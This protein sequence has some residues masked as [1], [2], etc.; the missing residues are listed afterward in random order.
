M[1]WALVESKKMRLFEYQGKILFKEM[2]IRTPQGCIIDSNLPE[3][4]KRIKFPCIAKVQSLAPGRGLCGGVQRCD[5]QQ[6]LE[7][8]IRKYL[9]SSFRGELVKKILVEDL[10]NIQKEYY[11]ALR[12]N[13]LSLCIDLIYSE[14]GGNGIEER[15]KNNHSA[16]QVIHID[17]FKTFF[18]FDANNLAKELGFNGALMNEVADLIY[19]MYTLFNK[20]DARLIEINPVVLTVNN[21]IYALD[22]IIQLDDDANFRQT[23]DSQ[24]DLI[25]EER[26]REATPR[27]QQALSID[28]EDY[29]GSVH[30]IDLDEHGEIGLLSVG[31]GFS[32]TVVDILRNFGIKP[33]NFC[34]CSGNPSKEKVYKAAK[35]IME[36]PGIKAFLFISGMVSQPL[37]VSAEGIVMAFKEVK[38]DIPIFVRMAGN[39]EVEAVN[40]LRQNGITETF[41]R[42][43]SVEDVIGRVKASI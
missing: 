16:I 9:N 29:R 22:A 42:L 24:I 6:D 39:Q 10:V 25:T 21:Q 32:I 23:L 41:S 40:Y 3:V 18:L 8:F 19:K 28:Q 2:G 15:T 20:Y 7:E 34:D 35:L 14:G 5:N 1:R 38:P 36:I 30:Y 43:S 12:I 37:D 17:P 27:E 11:F 33:A 13:S 4:D 31:S 26:P